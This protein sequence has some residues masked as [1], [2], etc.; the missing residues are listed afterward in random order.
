MGSLRR[1]AASASRARVASFDVGAQRVRGLV[2]S[3]DVLIG[4]DVR[5]TIVLIRFC[6]SSRL[7]NKKGRKI[8]F[9]RTAALN[10]GLPKTLRPVGLLGCRHHLQTSASIRTSFISGYWTRTDAS[11]RASLSRTRAI[12]SIASRPASSGTPCL[13]WTLTIMGSTVQNLPGPES[14]AVT[15]TSPLPAFTSGFFAS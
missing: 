6:P 8:L 7:G 10:K 11:S 3:R 14:L 4:D 2:R 15:S 1:S 13:A 12:P 9:S 5:F